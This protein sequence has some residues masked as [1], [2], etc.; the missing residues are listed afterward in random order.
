M[1]SIRPNARH[2][3]VHLSVAFN[4]THPGEINDNLDE[5]LGDEVDRGF[6]AD[7]KIHHHETP[8]IAQASDNPKPGELFS[9]TGIYLVVLTK[10]DGGTDILQVESDLSL[11]TM[12]PEHVRNALDA[13]TPLGE[14]HI[15]SVHRLDALRRITLNAR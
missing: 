13:N 12:T 14:A 9:V 10:S 3:I 6:I 8:F 2:G 7:Y 5:I 11:S 15:I 1:H 4:S